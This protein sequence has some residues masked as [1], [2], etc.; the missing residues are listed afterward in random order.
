MGYCVTRNVETDKKKNHVQN[1]AI[2]PVWSIMYR[3]KMPS[4]VV[5]THF[6]KNNKFR[7]DDFKRPSYELHL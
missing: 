7:I 3:T 2:Q 4:T 1:A 6:V 5:S